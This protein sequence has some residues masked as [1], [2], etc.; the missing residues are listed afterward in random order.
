MKLH[1]LRDF[2]AVAERGGLR[3]AARHLGLPQPAI[4][5]SIQE[6]EKELGVPLF[7]RGAKGVRLTPMGE[8]FLRRAN[9]VRSE[10]QRAKEEIDQLRGQ[11]HG[12]VTLCLSSVPHLALLPSALQAFR[13]RFPGVELHVIDAV[14]PNV[15]SALVEGRI[16][17][18]VGPMP[19]R[20]P[21]ELQGEKLFDNTRIIMGRKGHPLARSR[22]LRDLVDAE[23]ITTSITYKAEEELGP[24]FAEHGLPPPRL[25]MQAQS[26]LT[27]LVTMVYSDLLMMVP[28]QWVQF[29]LW[30]DVLQQIHVEEPLP[31]PPIG[32]VQRAGLPL[33]PAAEYFCDMVR[34]AS[35]QIQQ[36][37]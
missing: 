7:E 2:L 21:P 27:F 19:A 13:S 20:L 11:A 14:F 15:D 35:A 29:P 8:V 24:L 31:A 5:R 22:S 6:L 37:A 1:A 3:A 36:T 30:R 4:T 12:T 25:V 33:T 26:S 28:V 16:D 18:Y 32:I 10:L 23:W 17:F 34:R 9:A